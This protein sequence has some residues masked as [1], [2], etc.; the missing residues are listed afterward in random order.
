MSVQKQRNRW[1]AKGRIRKLRLDV[2]LG[3]FDTKEEAQAAV[4]HWYLKKYGSYHGQAV[5]NGHDHQLEPDHQAIQG[6]RQPDR[7]PSPGSV[8]AG[9]P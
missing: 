1:V 6:F 5:C 7:Q 3:G 2:Y 9:S 4:K 8:A